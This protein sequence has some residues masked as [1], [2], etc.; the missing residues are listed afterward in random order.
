MTFLSI[1][2]FLFLIITFLAYNAINSRHKNWIIFLASIFFIFSISIYA[3]LFAFIYIV[4][5]YSG[6]Q[7]LNKLENY[8]NFKRITFYAII[9]L[10]IGILIFYKYI[11]FIFENINFF[12]D[13]VK[14]DSEINK[15]NLILP[16]GISYYTFQSI[17]YLIRIYR[18]FE[19]SEKSFIAFSNFL[20]FFP[21]FISGP[22]ERSNHFIP[23]IKKTIHFS[24]SEVSNGIRLIML[25]AFK[26]IVIANTLYLPVSSV[27]N[28]VYDFTGLDLI[29]VLLIQLIYLYF[30]FSGYTDIAL[31]SAML[32]GI[33][34]ID[35]FNRPFLAKNITEFWKRWHISLSSWCNE[36]IYF[37]FIVKYRKFKSIAAILGIFL[38]FIII[39][40][41]HGANWTFLVLGL[42]Q[43]LAIVYEYFTKGIRLRIASKF[44]SQFIIIASRILV[45][46]FM[47]FSMIFFFSNSLSDAWYIISHLFENIEFNFSGNLIYLK[48]PLFLFVI[49]CCAFVLGFEVLLENGLDFKTFFLK[50]PRW[51]RWSIYYMLVFLSIYF[52]SRENTNF[53]Y[54]QF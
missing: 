8:H 11:N 21:K 7:L 52:L 18:G 19:I 28:N 4:I 34:I 9:G 17:G 22:V 32:F 13:V 37:P 44:H 41:W 38:T 15:I 25:G 5:N 53:V 50:R 51:I 27:Y 23:Q 48:K 35:N 31:G 3:L 43:A 49:T 33:N 36:F 42:L 24:Q 30:D 39:G 45:F 16:V 26:K 10:D 40:I 14:V 20:L 47:S 2:Y 54:Q 46:C 1:S 12:L 6:G 29:F